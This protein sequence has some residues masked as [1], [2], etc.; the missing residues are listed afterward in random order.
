MMML[1][2]LF[3]LLKHLCLLKKSKYLDLYLNPDINQYDQERISKVEE[4]P[5]LHRFD[6]GCAGEGGGH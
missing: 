2:Y 1:L 4:K 6:A 3:L 5:E